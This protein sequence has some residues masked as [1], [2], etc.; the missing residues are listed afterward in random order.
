M[1]GPPPTPRHLRLL[2][3]NPGKRPLRP[4][5]APTREPECPDPPPFVT[6]YA[7]DEWWRIAPELHRLGLLTVLDV[8]PLAAYCIAYAHWRIAEEKLAEMA[9]RD[10]VTSGL[11]IKGAAGDAR[12]NPL[13]KIAADAAADMVRYAGE[14]GM[15]AVARTRIAAS[16]GSQPGPSKFDGLIGG[17][18]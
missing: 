17:G 14:F 18:R 5:P 2:R 1:S 12:R 9:A 15:T 13:V 6:G 8:A 10:S 3:G 16:V 4:E 7:M 11:L